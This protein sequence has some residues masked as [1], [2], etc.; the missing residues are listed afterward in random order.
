MIGAVFLSGRRSLGLSMAGY[1]PPPRLGFTM[2]LSCKG[3]MLLDKALFD[4]VKAL[5]K[6]C[7]E[8]VVENG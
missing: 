2:R 3:T 8:Q 6:V 1:Y 4:S 5:N 7:S